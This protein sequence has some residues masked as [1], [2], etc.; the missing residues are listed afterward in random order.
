[1]H[2][3][4]G[5]GTTSN[6]T[7]YLEAAAPDVWT[8]GSGDTVDW[9]AST[10]GAEKNSG[11]AALIGQTDGAI[12]YVDLADASQG[13]P[14]TAQ[15]EN[16]SGEFVGPDRRRRA[17]SA[18]GRRAD[19]DLTYNPLN[20]AGEGAYPITSPTWI[21]TYTTYSDAE[22]VTS[23]Q[24][25]LQVRVHHGPGRSPAPRLCRDPGQL[26]GEGPRPGGRDNHRLTPLLRDIR[27]VLEKPDL[28]VVPAPA[29]DRGPR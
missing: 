1:M 14:L 28:P 24:T 5:S 7:K 12:G 4:D 15:I 8:L 2:R 3:S 11:V 20:A 18:R 16:S 26:P 19:E 29:Q 22:L 6:F 17:G 25:Y 23:L 10:Q 9:P 21:I 27:W 13:R